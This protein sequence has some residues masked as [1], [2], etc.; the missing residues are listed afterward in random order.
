MGALIGIAA[1]IIYYL[2]VS[3]FID[4]GS[5]PTGLVATAYIFIPLI[6]IP[7]AIGSARASAKARDKGHASVIVSTAGA[8]AVG[9]VVILLANNFLKPV[10]PD[11]VADE[12]TPQAVWI[13][14]GQDAVKA[15]LKDPGSV[16]F[17]GIYFHRGQDGVPIVDS[18]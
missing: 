13:A 3:N 17:R 10:A 8:V 16:Q 11:P 14:R 6:G 12:K 18:P 1:I 4:A 15:K 2:M 5:A 7:L 9:V